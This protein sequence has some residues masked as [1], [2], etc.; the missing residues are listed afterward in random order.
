VPLPFNTWYPSSP[1]LKPQL[2]DQLAIGY[3]KNLKD[4]TYE[5]TLEA[6]YKRLNNVTDFADNAD[7]FFNE[8]L[9]TEF[10]QGDSWSYGVE[11]QIKKTKGDLTGFVN[12][13]WSKTERLIPGVNQGKV[14]FAN[15]DRRNSV[16][17]L[18]SYK[19]NDNWAFST[20]FNY[21]SGRPITLPTGQ[22]QV[23]QYTP[24]Y[25]SE[26]NGYKLPDY[27]RMDMSAVLSPR[28][29]KNR[30]IQTNWVFSV[31]NLYNRKNAFT[32]YSDDQENEEAITGSKEFVM[33]YLFPVVPSVTFNMHF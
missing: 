28:K 5:G 9:A 15:Y 14:F 10:R 30:H 31:Y 1:Y 19:L 13:T 23:Q 11:F 8:N 2:A 25:I 27:H 21:S 17:V 18:A 7:I 29:N 16:N 26:R 32:I 12:Y 33:I 6:Y 22:Y 20:T 24:T 3:F 4:N